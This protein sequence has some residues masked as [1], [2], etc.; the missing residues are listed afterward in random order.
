MNDCGDLEE[1]ITKFLKKDNKEKNLK[2]NIKRK[3]QL[4]KN[5]YLPKRSIGLNTN[6]HKSD[7]RKDVA[8]KHLLVVLST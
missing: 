2:S 3:N 8:N 6:R 7:E 5:N 1:G 4:T